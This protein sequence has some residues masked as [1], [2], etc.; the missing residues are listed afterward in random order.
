MYDGDRDRETAE[1][2]TTVTSEKGSKRRGPLEH[3][4]EY[5]NIL[6]VCEIKKILLNATFSKRIMASSYIVFIYL[7]FSRTFS[8]VQ[9][10]GMVKGASAYPSSIFNNN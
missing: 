4:G 3:D 1:K 9:K 5:E 7:G 8:S 10:Q 6:G 2:M